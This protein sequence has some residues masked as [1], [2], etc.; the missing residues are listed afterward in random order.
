MAA[1][2]E[3]MTEAVSVKENLESTQITV[4]NI[5]KT[6][7]YTPGLF[8]SLPSLSLN[9]KSEGNNY[10]VV[11]NLFLEFKHE[12]FGID[13]CIKIQEEKK[14][15]MFISEDL[16]QKIIDASSAP[17]IL[18]DLLKTKGMTAKIMEDYMSSIPKTEITL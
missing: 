8:R 7:A 15:S 13:F 16:K 17:E 4:D 18:M 1:T 10:H 6:S 11:G 2:A 12:D 3:T 14:E 5:S 9:T